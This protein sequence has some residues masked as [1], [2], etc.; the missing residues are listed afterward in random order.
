[1][2]NLRNQAVSPAER[3]DVHLAGG[4]A[5]GPRRRRRTVL[6]AGRLVAPEAERSLYRLSVRL[7]LCSQRSNA[8]GFRGVSLNGFWFR[9]SDANELESVE[10]ARLKPVELALRDAAK[11]WM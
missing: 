3:L 10:Q 9:S 2:E 5:G 8:V 11:Q 4:R 6:W 1:V 7:L